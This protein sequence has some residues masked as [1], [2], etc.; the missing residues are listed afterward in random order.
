M[1]LGK[2]SKAMVK[3]SR[4]AEAVH[5]YI[6]SHRR[7]PIIVCGDFN[8]TPISY[9]RRTIASGLTDCYVET[10]CGMGIT[11]NQRGLSFRIDNIMCSSHFKPYGCYVDDEISV[12]DHNPVICWLEPQ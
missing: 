3:R 12:S 8:D 2:V 10:G 11:F 7:Y 4:Q 1:L 9:V 6:E 5:H